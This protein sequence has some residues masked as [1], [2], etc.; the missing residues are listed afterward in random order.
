MKKKTMILGGLIAA[1][2]ITGYSVAGTYAKYVSS[3][4]GGETAYIAQ[5]DVSTAS[6]TFNLFS[7]ASGST[8]Y[9]STGRENLV[10]PG[11]KNTTGVNLIIPA[12]T[13]AKNGNT[14]VPIKY[15]T[16]INVSDAIKDVVITDENEIA[17]LDGYIDTDADGN[18]YYSPIRFT[19]T[20]LTDPTNGSTVAVN[21]VGIEE[22]KSKLNANLTEGSDITITWEWVDNGSLDDEVTY[23]N[24]SK[25]TNGFLFN[26]YDTELGKNAF[27]KEISVEVTITAEQDT[28]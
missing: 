10:A 2:A 21:K 15:S 26:K 12:D 24:G 20:G 19:V 28:N 4:E 14:E 7:N 1:V 25:T 9:T 3:Q 17:A 22:L 13:N 8:V 16:S 5:W 23:A 18:K 27:N 11:R 6:V